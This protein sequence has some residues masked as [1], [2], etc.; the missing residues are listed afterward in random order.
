[1]RLRLLR[2]V[3]KDSS[4]TERDTY[5]VAENAMDIFAGSQGRIRITFA[6]TVKKI[7]RVSRTPEA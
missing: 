1:M 4:V 2:G 5:R 7:T 6:K 3:S